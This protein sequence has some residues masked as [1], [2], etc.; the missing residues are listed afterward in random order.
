MAY[1]KGEED[2]IYQVALVTSVCQL[3][4]GAC[5]KAVAGDSQPAVGLARAKLSHADTGLY[6]CLLLAC[7]PGI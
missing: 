7:A 6:Y 1:A 2:D 4:V 3:L 5:R